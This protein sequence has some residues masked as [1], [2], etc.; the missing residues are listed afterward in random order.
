MTTDQIIDATA[1]KSL[2]ADACREQPLVAWVISYDPP[3][4]SER[5]VA[6]LVTNRAWPYVV[7][8]DTLAK[9]QEQLPPGLERSDRQ[10]ADPPHVVEVWFY[11]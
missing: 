11:P 3:E 7:L 10:P 5:F 9:V 1:A 6:R 8:G 2:H 4:H